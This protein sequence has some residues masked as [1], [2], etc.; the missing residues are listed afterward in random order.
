M[1]STLEYSRLECYTLANVSSA[2]KATAYL[3]GPS[4]LYYMSMLKALLTTFDGGRNV[5]SIKTL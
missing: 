3:S 4:L 2:S 5:S 1:Y